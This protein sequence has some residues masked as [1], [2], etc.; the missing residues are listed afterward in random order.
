MLKIA[1][2]AV[3]ASVG[4]SKRGFFETSSFGLKG[5]NTIFT[6]TD[7]DVEKKIRQILSVQMPNTPIL[8]EELGTLFEGEFTNG[9]IID[10][11]DGTRAFLYGV[12][13]F[14]TLVAYIQD[15]VPQ[16]GVISFPAIN[17]IIYAS[18]GNGCWLEREGSVATQIGVAFRT[19]KRLCNA[20]VS[21]SGIHSTVFDNREGDKAYNLSAVIKIAQDTVFINDSYQHAMV[22]M[23]K[24]DCAID[25]LMKPW[26]IAALLPCLKEA[27]AYYANINGNKIDVM[28]GGSLV[29]ASSPELL[30]ELIEVLN[31]F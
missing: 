30:D 11:V 19:S 31:S 15:C 23:G 7:I 29:S 2:K 5:D 8:G 3:R 12:P 25:T 16:L 9:W 17:T 24:I 18:K 4:L 22:A 6:Q 20:V 1:L 28:N 26:D 27:G 13:L 10:P 14:S 21:A